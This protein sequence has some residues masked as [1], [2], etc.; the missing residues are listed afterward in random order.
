MSQRASTAPIKPFQIISARLYKVYICGVT[1][2]RDHLLLILSNKIQWQEVAVLFHKQ[3]HNE[4]TVEGGAKP[5]V[6][7]SQ[8]GVFHDP[9]FFFDAFFL[10]LGSCLHH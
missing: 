8:K 2:S 7:N 5:E 10:C 9:L 6:S 4:S 1:R 3:L